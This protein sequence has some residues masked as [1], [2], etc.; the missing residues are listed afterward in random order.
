MKFSGKYLIV[1]S[2]MLMA[3]SLFGQ[4]SDPAEN[5]SLQFSTLSWKRTIQDLYFQNASGEEVKFFVPN[6]SPSNTFDYFGPVPLVFYKYNGK[7]AQGIPIKETIARYNPMTR[8][9]RL[10]LFIPDSRPGYDPYR[11]LPLDYSPAEIKKGSYRFF[12]LASYPVYVRFGKN[13]FKVDSRDSATVL[14]DPSKADGLDVAMA[15]QVS[16]EADSARIVYSAGWTLR[17]GRSALVFIT[18]EQG[19]SGQIDVKRIY[20]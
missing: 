4:G 13:E 3:G 12:N 19:V 16:E 15:M 20:F 2:C 17:A 1:I 11:I 18:N 10:L 5:V 9:P 8:S 7:D 14:S 6:G